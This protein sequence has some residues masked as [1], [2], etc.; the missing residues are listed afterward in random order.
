MHLREAFMHVQWPQ[1]MH[2]LS[3][4]CRGLDELSRR[5]FESSA[6]VFHC[7]SFICIHFASSREQC[8][9]VLVLPVGSRSISL[10]RACAVLPRMDWSQVTPSKK[11]IAEDMPDLGLDDILD[12]PFRVY[13]LR[14]LMAFYVGWA[15][16]ED[17]RQRICDDF[18]AAGA[19]FTKRFPPTEVCLLWPARNAAAEAYVYYAL[20]EVKPESFVGGWTQ[21]SWNPSPMVH[22]L[23]R[24]AR[25]NL[26]GTWFTCHKQGHTAADC[27]RGNSDVKTCFYPCKAAGC[28]SKLHLTT[29]GRTPTNLL[30]PHKLLR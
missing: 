22:L 8:N 15:K 11:F 12:A 18:S 30:Q 29:T 23:T 21:T 13:V 19:G 24:E 17:V 25:C 6:R 26:K 10:L 28:T 5:P 2:V 27:P 4:G 16:T 3:C 1:Y 20:L 7:H 9:R 14:C